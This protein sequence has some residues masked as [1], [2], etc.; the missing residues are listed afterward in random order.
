MEQGIERWTVECSCG[1]KDDDGERMLACDKCGVWRH[2]IC[3]DIHDTQFVP[4]HFICLK[5]QNSDLKPKS[6]G[7]CKDET[8][9]NIIG[10]SSSCF[11]KGL[12]VPLDVH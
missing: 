8:L 5:C 11:G 10:S 12:P 7:N 3:S 4:T 1:A 6:I 2:T 9:T